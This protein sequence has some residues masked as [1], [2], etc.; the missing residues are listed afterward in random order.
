MRT[1]YTLGGNDIKVASGSVKQ[2]LKYKLPLAKYFKYEAPNVERNLPR[3]ADHTISRRPFIP[4]KII[5]T[6]KQRL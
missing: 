6:R 4:L 5:D 1:E 3:D 2:A